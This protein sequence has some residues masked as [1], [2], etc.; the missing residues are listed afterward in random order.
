ME[1]KGYACGYVRENG[2]MAEKG[3]YRRFERM[4]GFCREVVEKDAKIKNMQ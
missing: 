4:G 1:A 3:I 2:E